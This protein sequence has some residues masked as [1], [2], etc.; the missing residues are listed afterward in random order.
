L[1][2]VNHYDSQEAGA[3]F[4]AETGFAGDCPVLDTIDKPIRKPAECN[5]KDE[6]R[7]EID[8][9]DQ[10]LIALLAERH[11]YVRRIADFKDHVDE[12]FD[13]GRIEA[14]V[15]RA[16]ERAKAHRLDPD[17]AELMWRTLIAWNV[18]FEKGIISARHPE[19]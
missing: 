9:I 14:V 6:V 1:R 17:Q 16:R 5:S 3:L 8:R 4:A 7:V 2:I 15:G 12:A 10:G 18:N 11:A 13:P 19:E